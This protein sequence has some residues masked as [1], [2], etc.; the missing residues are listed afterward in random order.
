MVHGPVCS[1][2]NSSHVH[3]HLSL[4]GDRRAHSLGPRTH[5][6]YCQLWQEP[7]SLAIRAGTLCVPKGSSAGT[8]SLRLALHT[9]RAHV[10]WEGPPRPTPASAQG[11]APPG[12]FSLSTRILL[13]LGRSQCA[14]M[15]PLCFP[16]QFPS[17]LETYLEEPIWGNFGAHPSGFH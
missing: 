7:A 5:Q 17:A 1:G 16:R 14:R 4:P 9:L 3:T 8:G 12:P 10:L 13:P 6:H 2:L 11:L 15:A